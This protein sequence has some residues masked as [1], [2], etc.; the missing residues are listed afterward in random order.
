MEQKTLA[1]SVRKESGKGPAGRFR[2]SGKIP[3]IVYGR[4]ETRFRS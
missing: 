4:T 3:S 2:R 1:F